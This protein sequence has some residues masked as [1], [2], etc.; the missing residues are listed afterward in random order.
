MDSLYVL[1]AYRRKGIGKRLFLFIEEKLALHG[2]LHSRKFKN[3][4]HL[5]FER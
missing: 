1:P 5:K 3:L 2:V 4:E